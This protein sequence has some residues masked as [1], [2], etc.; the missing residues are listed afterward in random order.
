MNPPRPLDG[1][2]NTVVLKSFVQLFE[3]TLSL[4]LEDFKLNAMGMLTRR[5]IAWEIDVCLSQKGVPMPVLSFNPRQ[6]GKSI[7]ISPP[8][9]IRPILP[10]W[11][12]AQPSPLQQFTSNASPLSPLWASPAG[13]GHSRWFKVQ[14]PLLLLPACFLQGFG[15]W[16]FFSPAHFCLSLEIVIQNNTLLISSQV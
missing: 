2:N 11:H 4:L 14:I 8:S 3:G 5:F 6:Q 15:G 7:Y 16:F 13:P 10:P 9:L 12:I 1:T